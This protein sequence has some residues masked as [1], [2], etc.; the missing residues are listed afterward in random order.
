M[1]LH[2]IVK[3]KHNSKGGREAR[4]VV[5]L[6]PNVVIRYATRQQQQ[7]APVGSFVSIMC[8]CIRNVCVCMC[9]SVRGWCQRRFP[10]R[11]KFLILRGSTF[12]TYYGRGCLVPGFWAKYSSD[13]M[14]VPGSSGW[15]GSKGRWT[16]DTWTRMHV[17]GCLSVC[18]L[19]FNRNS[20]QDE[21]RE[22]PHDCS[23]MPVVR[24]RRYLCVSVHVVVVCECLWDREEWDEEVVGVY[25]KWMLR[26]A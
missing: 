6:Q 13:S 5:F 10:F 12:A 21:R 25:L 3:A 24:G 20:M 15:K 16:Q 11:Q 19:L 23:W 18:F 17:Y 1:L 2:C 4:V 7:P 8:R 26:V 14:R 9:L 22:R